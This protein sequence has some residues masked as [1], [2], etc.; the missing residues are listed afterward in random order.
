VDSQTQ[1]RCTCGGG[2]GAERHLAFVSS[3]L[4]AER[5]E[6]ARMAHVLREELGQE[7]AGISF[8]V[9]TLARAPAMCGTERDALVLRISDLLGAAIGRCR[10]TAGAG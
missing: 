9:G 4:A 5:S 10:D 3:E 2:V 1:Q 6:R 8:M 7:L